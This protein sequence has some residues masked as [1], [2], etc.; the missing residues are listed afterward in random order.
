M[1]LPVTV[2]IAD[3]DAWEFNMFYVFYRYSYV[4]FILKENR[5]SVS[6]LYNE[7]TDSHCKNQ[8]PQRPACR[9]L[10]FL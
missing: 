3:G 7:Q 1:F 5:Y 4:G 9:L 2:L 10:L 8:A 6:N